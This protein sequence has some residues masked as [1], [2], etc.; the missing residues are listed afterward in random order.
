M[1]KS[2]SF[3]PLGGQEI[4]LGMGSSKG[5]AILNQ[6]GNHNKV[7]ARVSPSK[8]STELSFGG[9]SQ[10]GDA[11]VCSRGTTSEVET[12]SER[13]THRRGS[14]YPSWVS[15]GKQR[16]QTPCVSEPG[17]GKAHQEMKQIQTKHG[18]NKS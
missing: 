7:P 6:S 13:L 9:D 4:H 15:H 17:P 2:L 8:P 18:D 11:L 14:G 1:T 3:Q 12:Q 10:A 5:S 16:T